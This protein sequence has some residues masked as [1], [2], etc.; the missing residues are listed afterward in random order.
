MYSVHWGI[1]LPAKTPPALSC[2]APP[3]KS[4]NCPRHPFLGNLP[5]FLVERLPPSP[6]KSHSLFPSNPPVKTEVLSS[7]PPPP[8]LLGNLV[9]GSTAPS[10][11]RVVHTMLC[12]FKCSSIVLL[13][14][15]YDKKILCI[16][17]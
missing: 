4:S 5:Y 9:G 17:L 14:I 6:Q 7:P 16:V 8:P 13:Y 12:V 10:E 15:F 11:T 2:Q 1:N 3:L